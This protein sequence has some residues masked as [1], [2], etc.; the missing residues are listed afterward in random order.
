MST[1]FYPTTKNYGTTNTMGI[2]DQIG[3]K[4]VEVNSA[5]DSST[6]SPSLPSPILEPEPTSKPADVFPGVPST[7]T[8]PDACYLKP[9]RWVEQPHQ[10]GRDKD[11]IR[12]V[13]GRCGKWIG[14]RLRSHS[15]QG[16]KT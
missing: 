11:Q 16:A 7:A 3:T 10:P 15:H 9:D 2:L 12:V 13:C 5:T 1:G 8:C 4:R 14:Y 6:P